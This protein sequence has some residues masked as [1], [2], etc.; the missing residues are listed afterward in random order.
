MHRYGWHVSGSSVRFWGTEMEEME[1]I[2]LNMPVRAQRSTRI[3]CALAFRDHAV[4]SLNTETWF[5]DLNSLVCNTCIIFFHMM[6]WK[7]AEK[8]VNS[9]GQ[10]TVSRAG[11]GLQHKSISTE[12]LYPRRTT[13]PTAT[14]HT[15]L[16]LGLPVD[17][18]LDIGD[19]FVHGRQLRGHDLQVLFYHGHGG[20]FLRVQALE[21]GVSLVQQ[22]LDQGADIGLNLVL[23]PLFLQLEEG[24]GG[25]G[26]FNT[27]QMGLLSVRQ[28]SFSSS[29]CCSHFS[30]TFTG[31]EGVGQEPR[32][33]RWSSLSTRF[34]TR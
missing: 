6:S 30:S 20:H 19:G 23:Q 3:D 8:S 10:F 22:E 17:V 26:R 31:L 16:K 33:S 13:S 34:C 28:Y 21:Q 15:D 7:G 9:A 4:Q 2:I 18:S 14:R 25:L 5:G 1:T 29:A 24:G 12:K 32:Q 27:T 11:N